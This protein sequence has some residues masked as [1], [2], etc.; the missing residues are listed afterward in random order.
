M[1]E[2]PEKTNDLFASLFWDCTFVFFFLGELFNCC[3]RRISLMELGFP[4]NSQQPDPIFK[5]W[6]DIDCF[7]CCCLS[8]LAFS[9]FQQICKAFGNLKQHFP[10]FPLKTPKKNSST[11][12]AGPKTFGWRLCRKVPQVPKCLSL[13][14]FS[15]EPSLVKGRGCG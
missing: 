7:F 6:F 11:P 8:W 3:G 12:S 10:P 5:D 15:W 9:G 1:F 14:Y 4:G 2:A 13:L